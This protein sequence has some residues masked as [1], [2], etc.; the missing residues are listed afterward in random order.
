MSPFAPDA[1]ST[2]R[3]SAIAVLL[4]LSSA[5]S[6]GLADRGGDVAAFEARKAL[7]GGG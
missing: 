4:L 1:R 5:P 2:K 7:A 6:I 3:K